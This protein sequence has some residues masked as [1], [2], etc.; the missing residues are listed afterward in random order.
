MIQ[1]VKYDERFSEEEL[2]IL[3]RFEGILKDHWIKNSNSTCALEWVLEVASTEPR[4]YAVLLAGVDRAVIHR[5]SFYSLLK[6]SVD[7]FEIE[8][9]TQAINYASSRSR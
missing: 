5:E 3:R 2:S 4:L 1:E 8:F 7:K 6:K 9:V